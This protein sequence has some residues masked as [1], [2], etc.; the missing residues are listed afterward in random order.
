MRNE[1]TAP[2]IP[3]QY[4]EL[5]DIGGQ[6]LVRQAD[7]N[8]Q[9]EL[10]NIDNNVVDNSGFILFNKNSGQRLAFAQTITTQSIAPTNP[11]QSEPDLLLQGGVVGMEA[12]I[13]R[14]EGGKPVDFDAFKAIAPDIAFI[15]TFPNERHQLENRTLIDN[16]GKFKPQMLADIIS[17]N[18]LHSARQMDSTYGK[19]PDTLGKMKA[20]HGFNVAMESHIEQLRSRI[21]AAD[22]QTEEASNQLELD[23][24]A[25]LTAVVNPQAHTVTRNTIVSPVDS[26]NS[27]NSR[28]GQQFGG[29]S[30]TELN[31]LENNY[32]VGKTPSATMSKLTDEGEVLL[33]AI[34][35]KQK[36]SDDITTIY[37]VKREDD[38]V[39]HRATAINSKT[40]EV[41]AVNQA[42]FEAIGINPDHFDQGIK[43]PQPNPRFDGDDIWAANQATEQRHKVMSA[44]SPDNLRRK[45]SNTQSKAYSPPS[46]HTQ[47]Q[48]SI[49]AHAYDVP[50][51]DKAA[52]LSDM[53]HEGYRHRAEDEAM[54]NAALK[55]SVEVNSVTSSQLEDIALALGYVGNVNPNSKDDTAELLGAVVVTDHHVGYRDQPKSTQT[56]IVTQILNTDGYTGNIKEYVDILSIDDS[57][58]SQNAISSGARINHP[59]RIDTSKITEL[60]P[61]I[62]K[63]DLV[64]ITPKSIESAITVTAGN[65]HAGGRE[66]DVERFPEDHPAL[67]SKFGNDNTRAEV[68][69][70]VDNV[71][72]TVSNEVSPQKTAL[73]PQQ[74]NSRKN[75][76]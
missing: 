9:F 72:Q 53:P 30:L 65:R 35:L 46:I 71:R 58:V 6:W 13:T 37:M 64:A 57:G 40:G 16:A 69:S 22:P 61:H 10:K 76:M 44:I 28:V 32:F 50:A 45:I 12:P 25:L 49:D 48:Y 63:H 18:Q 42:A 59:L 38:T 52:I 34:N 8:E 23:R 5:G 29:G 17:R 14:K 36:A 15:P 4:A 21:D 68:L 75:K 56:H 66:H 11:E 3:K 19:A 55:R 33:T 24:A 1:N 54:A 31:D 62:A 51:L 73:A 47:E 67:N 7:S 39:W 26:A 60:G 70:Y 2:P 43:W 20:V 74:E 27:I 41:S